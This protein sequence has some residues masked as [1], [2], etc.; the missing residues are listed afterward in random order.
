MKSIFISYNQ[1]LTDRVQDILDRQSVRGF[2]KWELTQGR[3]SRTGEPH[4]GSHTWPSV[5][6]S[7]LAVVDDAKVEGVMNALRKLDKE[8]PMQGLR[9]F[10]WHVE[11]AL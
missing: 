3:G 4:Y 10:V 11:E 1:A 9:A 8:L 6:S 7:V 5:N 2:T